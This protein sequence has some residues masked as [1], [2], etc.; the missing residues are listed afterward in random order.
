[1]K[2]EKQI[3]KEVTK[4]FENEIDLFIDHIDSLYQTNP[5]VNMIL[6]V[7]QLTSEKKRQEYV[8]EK[9]II[10]KDDAGNETTK[11]DF[12]HINKYLDLDKKAQNSFL[13]ERLIQRNFIVSL[14]SQFDAYVGSLIRKIFIIKPELLNGSERNLSFSKLSEYQSI[15]EAKEY[16]IEKEI[17][18]VLRDSHYNQFKWLENKLGMTL[19]K[20]LPSFCD[21]IEITERRNL[22]VHS[23]GVVSSQYLS[24]CNKHNYKFE[25]ILSTGE[26][27]KVDEKY[28][29]KAYNILFE[30]GVKLSQVIWRKL[31][32]NDL[33]NTDS[34]LNDIL[35]RLL[36]RREYK[37]AIN[38]SDFA[39]TILKKHSSQEF[40]LVFNVNK[41]QAYKWDGQEEICSKMMKNMD[42]SA[43]SDKFKLSKAILLDDFES[44]YKLMRKIGKDEDELPQEGYKEWPL[45]NKVRQEVEFK[46]VYKEIFEEEYEFIKYDDDYLSKFGIKEDKEEKNKKKLPPTKFK[47]NGE[48]PAKSKGK[49]ADK[50]NSKTES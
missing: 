40:K 43:M 2:E 48:V 15:N 31:L 13:A 29:A 10:A 47:S 42:W 21:F 8:D 35:Y 28:F 19:T 3:K 39:T 38:L 37:L 26:E 41:A 24:V 18:S 20:D 6:K 45:F 27:L 36:Q 33:E 9:G 16:I 25:T 32:P 50:G 11:I 4:D 46:K 44:V 23:N 1:M 49:V 17:E 34:S 14:V 30:I 7:T 5:M 12:R 22:F